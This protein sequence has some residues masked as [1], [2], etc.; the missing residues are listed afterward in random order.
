M[1]K[2]KRRDR[3]VEQKHKAHCTCENPALCPKIAPV[4]ERVADETV[5]KNEERF[6]Q[7]LSLIPDMVSIHD[8]D[9]NILYSNW[10]GFASVPEE[11]RIL[12]TKCY[13][14]YRDCE[15][16]CPDCQAKTVLE[17]TASGIHTSVFRPH[18]SWEPYRKRKFFLP[19]HK[20]SHHR[21]DRR[22][23]ATGQGTL[24]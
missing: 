23:H 11:K 15:D 10:N 13:R 7:M 16:I 5:I 3:L 19:A 14:T 22:S 12:G 6:Q 2:K 20:N 9:M 17:T 1:K 21:H 18:S 24:S 4:K 8:T